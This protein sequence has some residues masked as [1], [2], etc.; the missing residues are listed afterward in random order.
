MRV[1]IDVGHPAHVHYYKNLAFKLKEQGHFV[2]FT[3]RDKDVAL[4]LLAQYSL[5]HIVIGKPFKGVIKKIIGVFIFDVKLFYLIR[6]YKI[7]VVFSA[8]SFYAAHAAFL[9][10]IP[11]FTLEDSE[12]FEQIR[13]YRPFSKLIITP[14]YIVNLGKK[15]LKVNG[16]L[17]NSYLKDNYFNPDEKILDRYNFQKNKPT[18]LFRFVAHNATHDIG[19]EKLSVVGK[20][21]LIKKYENKA[22]IIISSETPLPQDLSKY[23]IKFQASEMHSVI[24]KIDL[25]IAESGAMTNESAFLGTPNIVIVDKDLNVH[26][27]YE[28]LGLK[29]HIKK[30]GSD[31]ESKIDEILSNYKEVKINMRERSRNFQSNSIDLTEFLMWIAL[32]HKEKDFKNKLINNFQPHV[33]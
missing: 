7:E 4:D 1:L 22:N 20:T 15:Q 18:L 33:Q 28:R 27:E 31:L 16:F 13:L 2:L 32:N 23:K 3:C 12:N 21:E 19:L 10:F 29:Y 26:K 17:Q 11:H 24:Y 8:G 25:L 5:K 6:K 30:Y 9:N 14:K